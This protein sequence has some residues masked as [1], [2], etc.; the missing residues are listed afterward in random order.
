MSALPSSM[1]SCPLTARPAKALK[2]AV[3][4]PGDKSQSHRALLFGLLASGPTTIT[5]LLE[6]DDVLATA[7]AVQALGGDVQRL[8]SGLWQVFGPGL[9]ALVEPSAPLDFGNA[10]TGSRLTMG[11][12]A[13]HPI[14][15]TFDGDASLRRRPMGRVVT[16]LQK[17]GA[18]VVHSADG[19]RLPLVLRGAKMPL[20]F[21][22][23]LDVASAQV[24]SALVFAALTSPG[25]CVIDEPVLTRDHTERM[26]LA[27]G[28]VI[29]REPLEGGGQRL[30]VQGVD[31][32][33]GADVQVAADPSSAAFPLVA[34]LLVEGSDVTVKDVMLNPLRTGLLTTLLEMG[35]DLTITPTHV[36]GGEQLGDVR[37]RFSHLKGVDVPA[38][39]APSMI[40]E[41][42]ILAVAAC[43]AEG[44][45][46]MRGLEELRVKESDRLSAV[47]AMVK[48]AGVHAHIEGDD[49][50]VEGQRGSVAGGG[51]VTTHMDHRLA[52]SGLVLGGAAHE[53]M[54][55]DDGA[56]IATS[57]PTFI[58]LM[59][60]LG[61]DIS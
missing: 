28:G 61:A 38:S 55:V 50:V 16:P 54:R 43:F 49:L 46:R 34:A 42:P 26:L 2:G 20:P 11:V 8:E 31:R 40:D 52:M 59:Q 45:T 53:G 18:R 32:L 13:G 58:T 47:A 23:R 29:E 19:L 7:R 22:H 4:V 6:G 33:Q 60:E 25:L 27:F 3:R 15:V 44:T 56:M 48:A 37:A 1:P 51:T 10:G 39:R 35:A 36:T 57:F 30:K 41:Y 5:G 9:G 24:K 17:V 21:S 12:V 14:E